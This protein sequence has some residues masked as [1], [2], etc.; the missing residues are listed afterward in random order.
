MGCS[1]G[2]VPVVIVRLEHVEQHVAVGLSLHPVGGGGLQT[3]KRIPEELQGRRHVP[4]E[5]AVR[6]PPRPCDDLAIGV[7]FADQV[8]GIDLG[9]LVI[10]P[11]V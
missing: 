10:A 8:D 5:Q 4:A 6:V 7:W 3:A 1:V 9:R 2:D 11:D